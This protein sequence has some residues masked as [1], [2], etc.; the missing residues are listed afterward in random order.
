MRRLEF[1][2]RD[3]AV[4]LIGL[5]TA[6][7]LVFGVIGFS[8]GV[9]ALITDS[10]TLPLELA[11]IAG[12]PVVLWAAHWFTAPV[13]VE[14]WAASE[15]GRLRRALATGVGAAWWVRRAVVAPEA[16]P[17]FGWAALYWIGD[18]ASLWAGLRSFGAPVSLPAVTIAY[19]TGY[20]AQ[21]IPIPLIATGGVDAATTL[22]LHE[23]G[24]P[25]EVALVGV[26]AHRIFAFWRPV[27]PGGVMAA[28]LPR[29]G[30][31]LSSVANSSQTESTPAPLG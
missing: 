21:S 27:V 22:V 1:P 24:V 4:R 14:R 11:W 17:L 10:A 15:G 20:L 5:S 23:L 26:V 12:I 25:L 18:I 16:R 19:V 8:A 3:A 29:L 13:R 2:R 30:R 9:V 31:S 6:V 28:L 7:Y